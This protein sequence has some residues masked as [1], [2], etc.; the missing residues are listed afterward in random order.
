[1]A[2]LWSF[3]SFLPLCPFSFSVKVLLVLWRVETESHE[4]FWQLSNK[5][6]ILFTIHLSGRTMVRGGVLWE[7]RTGERV[8][9]V[10]LFSIVCGE[11]SPTSP[12]EF[13]QSQAHS[14]TGPGSYGIPSRWPHSLGLWVKHML[15]RLLCRME[16]VSGKECAG[17]WGWGTQPGYC[18]TMRQ[19]E[20]TFS[21]FW[22]ETFLCKGIIMTDKS[23]M[24]GWCLWLHGFK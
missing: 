12:S 5:K 23:F 16:S 14:H 22:N 8:K 24:F 21:C 4:S 17:S 1:M 18:K 10:L 3:S 6:L 19:G 11:D 13:L 7:R 2:L 20:K 9:T 15:S